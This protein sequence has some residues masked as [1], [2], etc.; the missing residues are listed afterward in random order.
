ML[1]S[2]VLTLRGLRR[3]V[4]LTLSH[5]DGGSEHLRHRP[6][7]SCQIPGL[8]L[9]HLQLRSGVLL[10]PNEHS[11]LTLQ[12]QPS[13]QKHGSGSPASLRNP[14]ERI[15]RVPIPLAVLP[16]GP[17]TPLHNQLSTIINRHSVSDISDTNQNSM[18][19]DSKHTN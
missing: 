12:Q 18:E 7:I 16:E 5:L 3:L 1:Q 2:G 14:Q 4:F 6:D 17:N 9:D 10:Q 15:V 8:S 11:S 19:S 13:L